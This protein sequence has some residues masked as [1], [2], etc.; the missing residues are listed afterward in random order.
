MALLRTTLLLFSAQLRRLL[1][2]K[3]ML[4]CSLLCM[5]PVGAAI[6]ISIVADAHEDDVPAFELGWI[7]MIQ[8]TVPLVALI[9]GSAVVAEEVEDRTV[10]YL[11]SRPIPRASVLLGRWLATVVVLELLLFSSAEIT[12]LLLQRGAGAS[13]FALP[14]GMAAGM[15]NACLIGGL[16]YS[17][18]FAAGGAFL[19]HPMIVGI[20]YTFVVEGFLANLPGQNGSITIQLH[21]KSYLA[22]LGPEVLARMEELAGHQDLFAPEHALRRLA[23]V[24]VGALAL[25]CWTVSR[26]QYLLA[27]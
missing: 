17:A 6:L 8:G 9:L 14:A 11:F 22:G 4:I 23:F 27:S 2:S 5:A 18:L 20:G 10:S 3:R 25:G 21:L 24:L 16:V 1:L 15:R 12:F 13:E 19:K 7:L 26:R